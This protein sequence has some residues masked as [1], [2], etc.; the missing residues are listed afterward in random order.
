MSAELAEA[1]PATAPW[2]MAFAR[3]CDAILNHHGEQVLFKRCR[4]ALLRSLTEEDWVIDYEVE[5]SLSGS[6]Q[7]RVWVPCDDDKCI[8]IAIKVQSQDAVGIKITSY[9]STGAIRF[10]VR[11]FVDQVSVN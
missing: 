5:D 9:S 7:L 3:M 2:S 4:E 10:L 8:V 6:A 11:T 1:C